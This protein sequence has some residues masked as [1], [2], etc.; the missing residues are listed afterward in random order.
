MPLALLTIDKT[1]VNDLEPLA[2]FPSLR[3]LCIPQG[4]SNIDV[5]RKLPQLNYLAYGFNT[6]KETPDKLAAD[7][8]LEY[9]AA[10]RSA[11]K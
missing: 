9:D 2:H 11:P 8:W 7:F 6:E 4:A 3:M 10:Q 1:A 5:L